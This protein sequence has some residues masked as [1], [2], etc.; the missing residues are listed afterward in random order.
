LIPVLTPLNP[1]EQFQESEV[2]ACA[3]AVPR[4]I[5]NAN[6][7]FFTLYLLKGVC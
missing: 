2:A 4:T 3:D 5:A 7:T 6:N 1:K